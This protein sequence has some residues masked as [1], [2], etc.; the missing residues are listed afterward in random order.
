[1]GGGKRTVSRVRSLAAFALVALALPAPA[2]VGGT[3]PVAAGSWHYTDKGLTHEV[4]AF[5]NQGHIARAIDHL[6][7]DVVSTIVYF[8]VVAD[9]YGHLVK[10]NPDGSLT[11]AWRSWTGPTMTTLIE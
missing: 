3:A 4:Y 10:R 2:V 5:V 1:M 9:R 6:D 11:S 7:H 8:S